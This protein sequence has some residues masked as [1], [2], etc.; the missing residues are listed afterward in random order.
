[1][2]PIEL[3]MCVDCHEFEE[4]P[5]VSDSIVLR[6]QHCCG[7]MIEINDSDRP[8]SAA[9][10][11]ANDRD[12]GKGKGTCKGKGNPKDKTA[13]T[14][15]EAAAKLKQIAKKTCKPNAKAKASGQANGKA[16]GDCKGA[17]AI[18]AN[19][20]N[21]EN[22]PQKED[23]E[24]E[25]F[26]SSKIPTYLLAHDVDLAT[27][28]KKLLDK[29]GYGQYVGMK[30]YPGYT[31]FDGTVRRKTQEEWAA[32]HSECRANWKAYVDAGFTEVRCGSSVPVVHV[33]APTAKHYDHIFRCQCTR[34]GTF[35]DQRFKT[36]HVYVSCCNPCSDSE[37]ERSERVALREGPAVAVPTCPRVI[38]SAVAGAM[39][40][41]VAMPVWG[42]GCAA[43]MTEAE[44]NRG[45]KHVQPAMQTAAPAQ[46]DWLGGGPAND[47]WGQF[48][49]KWA[50]AD[51]G[52][53]WGGD[54]WGQGRGGDH[55]WD[56]Y[57]AGHD[58]WYQGW[59]SSGGGSSGDGMPHN[60]SPGVWKQ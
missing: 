10:V 51:S 1:M 17:A 33:E 12:N 5:P 56:G 14:E 16:K 58:G 38:T 45:G 53:G 50:W 19:D 47:D 36:T 28:R 11:G 24:E 2:E 37:I 31:L 13:N 48:A 25:M 59:C 43:P 9:A 52:N 54:G 35:F 44:E 60:A 21:S 18:A 39:P 7:A 57:R 46:W 34:C 49:G 55:G 8:S 22:S 6:C 41:A 30:P 4:H 32:A 23:R 29:D 42:R 20:S 15:A 26:G 27:L 40:V 3:F